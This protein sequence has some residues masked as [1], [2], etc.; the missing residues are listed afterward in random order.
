MKKHYYSWNNGTYCGRNAIKDMQKDHKKVN[1]LQ[2]IE[3]MSDDEQQWH[4]D[5]NKEWK[6][7]VERSPLWVMV[8]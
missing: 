1:C 7:F 3:A 2:C 5:N 8:D 4:T 6:D